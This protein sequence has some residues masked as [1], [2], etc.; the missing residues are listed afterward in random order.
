MIFLAEYFFKYL[1][2][3]PE[4]TQQYTSLLVLLSLIRIVSYML[5]CGIRQIFKSFSNNPA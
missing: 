5:G 2:K 3:F 4:H 1:R